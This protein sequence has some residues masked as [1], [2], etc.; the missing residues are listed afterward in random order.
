VLWQKF[1]MLPDQ[2][3]LLIQDFITKEYQV[4]VKEVLDNALHGRETANFEF[5]L[6]TKDKRRV[7]VLLNATTR[8]DVTGNV[9]GVLGVGQDI[10]ERKQVEVEKTRVAQELQTFIDTANAPI[11]GIDANGLVNE[12]NNKAAAI[13][14]FSCEEVLGRNLVHDFITKEYQVSVKEVLDNA[15]RG[16][17]AANFEFPLYTRDQRR[18]EVLLNATT[19]RD[20]TGKVVGVIGVGQD[21]TERKQVE[22]EKTRVAQELQ[23]FIDTANAPIFGIDANGLVNEWNNK[24]AA[25][26]GFS[27]EE[28]LGRNLV[29]DF[30]TKEYQVSVKEVLDNALQGRET[31][32]FEFPLYTKD[33]RRVDVL[34]NAT[35]RRDVNGY[36]VGVLGVGQD[37]TERKQVEIEKTRVAQ[38]LQTFIDTAN[39]PIFGIDANGLV[40]E[41]NNKAAEIT[42][43]SKEE[44]L[45]K[46]LVHA[47]I[48]EEFRA[49]V[50]QVLDKALSGMETANFEFP[51]FTKNERRVEVLLNATTRR[52]VTGAIVGVIGVGQDITERKHAEE[53]KARVALELQ[54]FIDT[55]NAPIFGIDAKGLVDE[56][57][58]KAAA[59]TGFSRGEVLGKDLVEVYISADFRE[60]VNQVLQN[61]LHG[62][63]TANFEFP[64]YTKDK[65]R[66]EVL[67]NAT[68]RRDVSGNV[69]GVLGVGQDITERKQVEVEK[70]RV[71]QELR[72]FIDTANA[73]IFG[74]DANG[75]VNE[76][77][78]KA[79]A[80]TG[81]DRDEV[82]GKN[83]VEVI[84][85]LF[86]CNFII[87]Y[88]L[89]PTNGCT[90]I[91]MLCQD[92]ITKEYQV[93]VSEVLD[94]A[95]RGRETANFE[96]PLYTKDQRRVEVLFNATT[97]RDV[98]GDVV[99]VL[100][101]GQ[102]ITER[103]QVEVEK[104]RVAQELQTFID[105][106]NAPIFGIDANGLVNEWNNKAAAITGFSRE[107]VL[108]RNLVQVSRF[109]ST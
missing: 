18:V 40:N 73:P 79:A 9:V 34:L 65:R 72:T 36:V 33:Q 41:W 4:S 108:G 43:F 15:L 14:G 71:A 104:T 99:G 98:C 51:L 94:N 64:L 22:M 70:A 78:N 10:T 23:T 8:R 50:K 35:T 6:Y 7:E 80:I 87:V 44:V 91:C 12:W 21:I 95:L 13:T 63:E 58:N 101:V 31:A 49:S 96:F 29:H 32:N 5:P 61:A 47:Y 85:S 83:L 17:E 37:I 2:H 1:A 28:V 102:D 26:T 16:R 88:R 38:E 19:R 20:V 107:E 82:L 67:L 30:I 11:F 24:S 66:V 48:T 25:I 60:S 84:I 53:E 27:R 74:I 46:D 92:F 106:A 39:A 77:N 52:D 75:L 76:W 59:I 90:E 105:T 45:G 97:R 55:A 3:S 109:Q 89:L 62:Q 69:V 56:W 103:K 68:T 54:S 100:G 93:S 57:N 42:G 81:F 86:D